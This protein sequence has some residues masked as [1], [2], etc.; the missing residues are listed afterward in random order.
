MEHKQDL[1]QLEL[2]KF[3]ENAIGKSTQKKGWINV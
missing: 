2:D 1:L 3:L